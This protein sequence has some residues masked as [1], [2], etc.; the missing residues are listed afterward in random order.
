MRQR[1]KLPS[2]A[3]RRGLIHSE[4]SVISLWVCGEAWRTSW[5]EKTVA[6]LFGTVVKAPDR[7]HLA[8]SSVAVAEEQ[9]GLGQA[10]EAL[11]APR[12]QFGEAEEAQVTPKAIGRRSDVRT[13]CFFIV[14]FLMCS[15]QTWKKKKSE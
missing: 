10:G 2:F 1:T 9:G 12:V 11:E 6:G 13:L 7:R 15:V 14:Y 4:V 3:G 5:F 8:C